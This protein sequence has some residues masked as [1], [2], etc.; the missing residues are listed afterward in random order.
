MIVEQSVVCPVLIGRAAPLSTVFHTLDRAR[1]AHGGALLLSGEA[2]IGKSR[3]VR[4]MIE[5]ARSDGFVTLQGA[6]FEADRAHPYAPLLDLVRSLS[7]TASPALTAHYFAAA[8]A[9]LVT[10]FPEL[11]AIF[12]ETLPRQTFDPEEDRR[13]LF[14]CFSEAIHAIGSVQPLLLVIEDVHW[15][16][17]ATLDLVL[18]LARRISQQPIAMVLT[19]RSDEIGQRLARL[20]ADLDRARVASEVGLRPL[21][22]TDVSAMLQ[23]IF[24]SDVTFDGSFVNTLH[25]LTEEIP[26]SSRRCSRRSLSPA[27]SRAPM[28][29]GARAFSTTFAFHAR[30]PRRWHVGWPA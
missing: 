22:A 7:T 26:F 5:R 30:Q 16:D 9:E 27:I 14:H 29:C 2:G 25:G 15:S 21:G 4:A 13:R 17:D 28:V 23:A 11:Q 24:G 10:L 12:R 3:L 19:F 18:Y 1:A 20:L 6:C 8:G